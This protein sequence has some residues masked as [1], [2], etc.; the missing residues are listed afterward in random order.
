MLCSAVHTYHSVAGH[1][2]NETNLEL[3]APVLIDTDLQNIGAIKDGRCACIDC[4]WHE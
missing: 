4:E 2:Q 1:T 3:R